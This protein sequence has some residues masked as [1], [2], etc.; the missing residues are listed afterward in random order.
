MMANFLGLEKSNLVDKN[1]CRLKS[2]NGNDERNPNEREA[3]VG[4]IY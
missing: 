2:F 4:A 3:Y 1:H